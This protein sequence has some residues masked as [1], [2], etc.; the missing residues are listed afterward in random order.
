MVELH[1]LFLNLNYCIAEVL[2]GI[3]IPVINAA[4]EESM[5]KMADGNHANML[6]TKLASL[7]QH[8]IN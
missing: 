6:A 8:F 4:I 1:L 2:F 7:F 3:N 5:Q